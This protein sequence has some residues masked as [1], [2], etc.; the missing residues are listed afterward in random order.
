MLITRK[1]ELWIDNEDK[2]KYIKT[3][4]VTSQPNLMAL[5]GF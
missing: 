5:K 2:A 1:I 4:T 3:K